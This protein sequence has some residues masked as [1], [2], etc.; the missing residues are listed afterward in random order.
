MFAK[1]Q[2]KIGIHV[3]YLLAPAQECQ[4]LLFSAILSST[5]R[6]NAKMTRL[7]EARFHNTTYLVLSNYIYN[8]TLYTVDACSVSSAG[9]L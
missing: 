9:Q 8:I 1:I 4:R 2:M 7:M 3:M 6:D 5:Q